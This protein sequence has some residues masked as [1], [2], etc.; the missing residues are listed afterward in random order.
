MQIETCQG[1]E[2]FQDYEVS[3][4]MLQAVVNTRYYTQCC[5][6]LLFS[7]IVSY[8]HINILLSVTVFDFAS[9]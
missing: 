6:F 1:M 3:G 7:C 4:S 2:T 8:W 5:V 9:W